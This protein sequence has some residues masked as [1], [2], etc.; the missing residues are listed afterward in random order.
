MVCRWLYHVCSKKRLVSGVWCRPA[1]IPARRARSAAPPCCPACGR[2]FW[3]WSRPG[4]LHAV[5]PRILN[6]W[7]ADRH[8]RWSLLVQVVEPAPVAKHSARR[9]G[10]AVPQ[11]LVGRFAIDR[12]LIN[13]GHQGV[14]DD[15]LPLR[16][17]LAQSGC[18]ADKPGHAPPSPAF[19]FHPETRP[20]LRPPPAPE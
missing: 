7:K 5:R 20:A 15:L 12:L 8:T 14:V 11:A 6:P 16:A 1:G 10:G 19:P 13:P 2:R 18:A 9:T 17:R 4:Y 3:P